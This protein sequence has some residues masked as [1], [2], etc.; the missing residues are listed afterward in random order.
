[1]EWGDWAQQVAG[2]LINKA[3]DKEWVQ[4]YEI[5]KMQ[6]QALGQLGMYNEGQA[7]LTANRQGLTIS[8]TLLLI[9]A[10]ALIVV[11]TRD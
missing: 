2:S 11:M 8:P 4:P 5:Q 10:V 3:S 9:G 7:S 6:L 1:M